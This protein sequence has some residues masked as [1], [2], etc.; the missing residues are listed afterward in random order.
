LSV[1]SVIEADSELSDLMSNLY[2]EYANEMELQNTI[3]NPQN[4]IGVNASQNNKEYKVAFVESAILSK[5]YKLTMEF[6]RQQVMI[7]Q[8]TPQGIIQVPQEQV[9]MRTVEQGWK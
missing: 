3:W 6:K 5:V 7:P 4:E 2:S 9:V 1:K 8:Q